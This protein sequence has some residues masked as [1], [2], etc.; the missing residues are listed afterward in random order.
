V[1]GVGP[2]YFTDGE[3]ALWYDDDGAIYLTVRNTNGWTWPIARNTVPSSSAAYWRSTGTGLTWTTYAQTWTAADGGDAVG[4]VSCT[5]HHG[6]TLGTWDGYDTAGHT[7][8]GNLH[9]AMLG[10]WSTL[11]HPTYSGSLTPWDRVA[12]DH[13]TFWRQVPSASWWGITAAFGAE[14][15][16]YTGDTLTA[17]AGNGIYA[18]TIASLPGSVAD[19]ILYEHE[20]EV[21]PAVL[22]YQ[23]YLR[24]TI[25]DGA[26]AYA[27]EVRVGAAGLQFW[28]VVAGASLGT[29]AYAGGKI[30]VAVGL[31]SGAARAWFRYSSPVGHEDGTWTEVGA[32]V[33]TS[34][35]A[36]GAHLLEF[37]VIAGN[38][39]VW[40]F[41][42]V[43][44][45]A[46]TG[47][48][49]D[50]AP[51]AAT[52]MPRTALPSGTWFGRNVSLSSRS[53][54]A[55]P[56]DTWTISRSWEYGPDN[57]DP[58][59]YTPSPRAACLIPTAEL[60]AGTTEIRIAWTYS[61]SDETLESDLLG[62]YLDGVLSSAVSVHRRT[63][64]AWVLHGTLS[65]DSV[66]ATGA[67][68]VITADLTTGGGSERWLRGEL[69][70]AGCTVISA[71][72]AGEARVIFRSRGGSTIAADGF[73]LQVELDAIPA[74]VAATLRIWPRRGLI[75]RPAGAATQG[76][77]IRIPVNVAPATIPGHPVGGYYG[78]SVLAF[79]PILVV[80]HRAQSYPGRV[81]EPGVEVQTARDGTRSAEETGPAARALTLQWDAVPEE[82]LTD[83]VTSNVTSPVPIAYRQDA[84]AILEIVAHEGG[85]YPGVA[86]VEVAR[87]NTTEKAGRG[88]D[89][90][91]GRIMGDAAVDPA[92]GTSAGGR[93]SWV[94]EEE[95]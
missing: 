43:T 67:G 19:G 23:C 52:L 46:R 50:A 34:T 44:S 53:G 92:T 41:A 18:D 62:A 36:A 27:V 42:A 59:G 12:W 77:Q 70:G 65:V 9:I 6:R 48:K 94:I 15:I 1:N 16:S 3:L 11:T 75:Y 26:N 10:G 79:G 25:G 30:R 45:D 82:S 55:Y 86:V 71:A 20:V 32:G 66:T 51:T 47:Q 74:I 4:N 13:A 56:P 69:D 40:S 5:A 33:P 35:G 17:G 29:V 31:T 24:G 39:V 28:D 95:R 83:Y 8:R 21:T 63:G 49:W 58:R 91:Y 81:L 76:V 93:G 68:K 7:G 14:V 61:T 60:P 57:L 85:R 78:L 84:S 64:A 2:F 54:P 90:L 72:P 37:I 38:T 80:G 88:L 87:A 89:Y 73:P 22:G